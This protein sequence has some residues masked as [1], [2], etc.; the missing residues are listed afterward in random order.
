MADVTASYKDQVPMMKAALRDAEDA[1]KVVRGC[2]VFG[3]R[4]FPRCLPS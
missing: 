1:L 2:C 4:A 3:L